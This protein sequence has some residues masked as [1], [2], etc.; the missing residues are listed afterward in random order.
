MTA[1]TV[2]AA[3]VATVIEGAIATATV[4]SAK[5]ANQ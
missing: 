1:M 4:D 5:S 2:V 3:I